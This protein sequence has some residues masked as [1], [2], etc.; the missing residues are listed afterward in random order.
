MITGATVR[1]LQVKAWRRHLH[2]YDNV[3]ASQQAEAAAGAG[4]DAAGAADMQVSCVR[5]V[6]CPASMR[7][8]HA[9]AQRPCHGAAVGAAVD[10]RR[11][12]AS[13]LQRVYVLR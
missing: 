2:K 6:Y 8:L 12:A 9:H 13:R 10:A 3:E 5:R 11:L 7:V 1:L 4:D